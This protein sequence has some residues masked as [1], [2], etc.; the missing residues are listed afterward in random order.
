[1]VAKPGRSVMLASS[2]YL[3]NKASRHYKI[4]SLTGQQDPNLCRFARQAVLR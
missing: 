4:K 3:V 2:S 1:M